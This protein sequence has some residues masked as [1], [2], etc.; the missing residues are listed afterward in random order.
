MEGQVYVPHLAQSMLRRPQKYPLWPLS[1]EWYS[2]LSHCGAQ[3]SVYH[4]MQHGLM[5]GILVTKPFHNS[6]G[7]CGYDYLL[8]VKEQLVSF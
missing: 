8:A 4:I 1:F 6:E 7:S 5:T 3:D 2:C